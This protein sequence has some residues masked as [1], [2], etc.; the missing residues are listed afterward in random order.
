MLCDAGNCSAV[1]PTTASNT[2][3]LMKALL[4]NGLAKDF[5][6]CEAKP[7]DQSCTSDDIGLLVFGGPVPGR[8]A[9]KGMSVL[10]VLGTPDG[11]GLNLHVQVHETWYGVPL[12]CASTDA[13]VHIN[14]KR[15]VVLDL[16]PYYC[17]WAVVGNMITNV[18]MVFDRIDL[19]ERKLAAHYS[20]Q[21]AGTA[22]G[23]GSGYAAFTVPD[24]RLPEQIQAELNSLKKP[25]LLTTTELIALP[26]PSQHSTRDNDIERKVAIVLGNGAYPKNPLAN[27][28]N[29]AKAISETLKNM[30]FD[31]ATVLDANIDTMSNAIKTFMI[32]AQS[33][34]I[35]LIY[36]SGHGVEIN[37]KNFLVATDVDL[38]SPQQVLSH[39]IDVTEMY[40]SGELTLNWRS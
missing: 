14:E 20:I 27:T 24:T 22:N 19:R 16:S 10:S 40:P 13:M 38:S 15:Q 2:L 29:D 12:I 31:V 7:K 39:S 23:G 33:S 26:A 18:S 8:G 21:V 1:S 3:L 36:Y 4:A 35:A 32:D 5:S 17:N 25:Q 28:L 34:S 6:P 30:G 9:V 37:G 11:R